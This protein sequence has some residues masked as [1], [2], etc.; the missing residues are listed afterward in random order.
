M[1]K[2]VSVW[3]LIVIIFLGLNV[4][5]L[6]GWCV[7]YVA[8]QR[9]DSLGKLAP[10]I[11]TIAKFP[12]LVKQ[13]VSEVAQGSHLLADNRFPELDGFKKNGILPS[14]V[15]NDEGYLLVSAYDNNRNQSS[16]KLIRINDQKLIQ[17]WSPNISSLLKDQK[18]EGENFDIQDMIESGDQLTNPILLENGNLI[19]GIGYDLV[20]LNTCSSIE[21]VVKGKFHHLQQV[22]AEG[23]YWTPTII[24]HD[25][26]VFRDDAIAK[27]SP[28]GKVLLT[29]SVTEILIENGYRGLLFGV[30][31]YAPDP[32]HFI[33]ELSFV[34]DP[35]HLNAVHP[36]LYTTKYWNKGDL[37]ISSRSLSTVFIYR[38]EN[39]KIIWLKTG[40]W[41]K[42]H[43]PRFVGSSKIS[44]FGNDV[45]DY[46]GNIGAKLID[47]HN[48]FYLYDF[49]NGSISTPYTEALNKLNVMTRTG[50]TGTILDDGDVFILESNGHRILRLSKTDA[51][52]EYIVKVDDKTLATLSGARYLSKEQ[53]KNTLPLLGTTKCH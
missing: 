1:K 31:R 42:Q 52:W 9:G 22:D 7:E 29:K 28:D 18:T 5:V 23:N 21:M 2:T 50:G 30:G 51:V 38:P 40:P 3:L 41:L 24:E 20:K 48:N 8:T 27:I 25:K 32:T 45:L 44:V 49:A 53:A 43:N 34:P 4:T 39:N 15:T 37:L 13:A 14:G 16:V 10:V 12:S 17:E 35:I 47:G 11:L 6:F 26:T 46:P 19:V 33:K 36:A